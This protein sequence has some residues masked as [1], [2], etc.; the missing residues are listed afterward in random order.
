MELGEE[1]IH[2]VPL[3]HEIDRAVKPFAKYKANKV[4]LLAVTETFGK[5]KKEMIDKQKHYL[6]AVRTKLQSQG[7]ICEHRNI[8]MF[9]MLE[10]TKHIS[11]IITQEKTKNNRIYINISS[12]GRLT[13]VAATL[14]AMAHKVRAY[15]VSADRYSEN[16]QEQ[17]DHGLS[18]C[19]KLR[20]QFLENIPIQ[21]PTKNEMTLLVKLCT[22]QEGMNTSE[23]LKHLADQKIP[24]YE[25]C[26][27]ISVPGRVPRKAKINYLMKLNKGILNKLETAG[28][29]SRERS[30]KYNMIRITPSGIYIAHVSGKLPVTKAS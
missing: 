3:G 1:I 18:Y 8:D 24:G 12:A 20:L 9:D 11:D 10:V 30:G 19:E 27:N 22:K 4:Y 21:L 28:Y 23:L 7:I 26:V 5:Y 25:E 15:Y 17:K 29:I 14:T 2:I 13:A 6:N 16:A